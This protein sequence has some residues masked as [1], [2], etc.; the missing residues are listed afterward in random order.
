[1]QAVTAV[2]IRPS[3]ASQRP[4]KPVSGPPPATGTGTS[5]RA[6]KVPPAASM[7]MSASS[8]PSQRRVSGNHAL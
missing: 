8:K 6:P 7:V 3:R 4:V 1:M 5:S 2:T